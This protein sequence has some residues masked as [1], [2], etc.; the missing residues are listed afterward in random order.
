MCGFLLKVKIEKINFKDRTYC[1][2][3]PK[4]DSFLLES[5]QKFGLLQP[6]L[7]LLSEEN[8]KIVAGEGRIL[9]LKKLE[10]EE[11]P[12][13]VINAN[14]PSYLPLLLSLESNLFRPL[15]LVEKAEFLK[16]AKNY[17]SLKEILKLLPKLGFSQNYHWIEFLEKVDSL[18]E[19]FKIFLLEGK[20]NPQIIEL[21][22]SL[23]KTFQEEFLKLVNELKLSFSE[24]RE[25]LQK[26]LDYRKRK[27]LSEL[28]PQELKEILKEEDFNKRK[29]KFF[30]KLKELLFPN[31][32]KRLKKI[33][34]V[35]QTFKKE[36]IELILSP[37][38]EKKEI[39]IRFKVK[40]LEDLEKKVN[41]LKKEKLELFFKENAS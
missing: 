34:P 33:E 23:E 9:A 30:E 24:Q 39:E 15:N 25:V 16:R 37:F 1:F 11:F 41:F 21:F 13:L 5:I 22:T 26:L 7:L 38:L 18:D 8:Y 2:S 31:Y 10:H 14:T 27:D 29:T 28:L 6:P 17:F 40:N 4:R 3:F 12:A 20:L 36:K 19:K 35:I 32:T